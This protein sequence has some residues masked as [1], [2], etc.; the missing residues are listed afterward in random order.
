MYQ[1]EGKL[2]DGGWFPF[3]NKLHGRCTCVTRLNIAIRNALWI[4]ANISPNYKRY[5]F[6]IVDLDTGETVWY[7]EL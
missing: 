5:E 4:K 3:Q 2:Y 6:R 1:I 7:S